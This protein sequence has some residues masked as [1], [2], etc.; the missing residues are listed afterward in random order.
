[1]AGVEIE[2]VTVVV[3]GTFTPADPCVVHLARFRSAGPV[4]GFFEESRELSSS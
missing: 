3:C 4:V 2:V 1:M